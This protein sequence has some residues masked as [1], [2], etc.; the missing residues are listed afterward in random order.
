[1]KDIVGRKLM[2]MRIQAVMPLIRGRLLDIGCGT[3][4]LARAYGSG[5]GVDVYDWGG[6]DYVVEDSAR[7][8]FQDASFDTVTII[9]ALNHISNREEVL[10]E[11][12]RLLTSDGRL[13]ITMISPRISAVW[14]S[15]RSPWDADQRERGMTEGEVFGFT[16]EQ[17]IELAR[18]RGFRLVDQKRFM[19]WLNS[20]YIF[21]KS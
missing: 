13:I 3:N 9:A 18:G 12:K 11:C 5:V 6:V 2:T 15:L 10:T 19:L 17:L 8:P 20:I 1:M 16:S 4:K 21:K 7:L 14:H